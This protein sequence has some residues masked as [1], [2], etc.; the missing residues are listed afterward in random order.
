MK[1]N[2]HVTM[3]AITILA[4]FLASCTGT[5]TAGSEALA[6]QD[7]VGLAEYQSWKA[8]KELAALYPE[9]KPAA[10]SATGGSSSY[11]NSASTS[12]QHEAKTT[13]KKGWSKAAKGAV[14]GA[15]SGAAIGAVVN[16]K[17]RAIGAVIGGIIGGGGGYVVGRTMDKKDGRY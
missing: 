1:R 6:F 15:G 4:I 11:A 17:N 16:K 13:E 8:K 10:H 5:G 2:L 14:I 9:S 7:T 3:I 12:S